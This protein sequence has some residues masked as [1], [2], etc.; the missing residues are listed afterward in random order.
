MLTCKKSLQW[1]SACLGLILRRLVSSAFHKAVII[2]PVNSQVCRLAVLSRA[3]ATLA[4][5]GSLRNRQPIQADDLEYALMKYS[6]AYQQ[7][8]EHALD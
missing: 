4:V 7:M 6:R 2:Y 5:Q 1:A 3:K 8:T